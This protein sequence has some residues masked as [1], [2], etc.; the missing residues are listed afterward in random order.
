MGWIR[1]AQSR[2]RK[3]RL[4]E[5]RRSRG[6]VWLHYHNVASS[7]AVKPWETRAETIDIRQNRTETG[8][9]PSPFRSPMK[10]KSDFDITVAEVEL[11]DRHGNTII[12]PVQ[13]GIATN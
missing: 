1:S 7:V 3:A 6:A 10:Q 8:G 11:S 5:G 12:L 2:R 4:L 13:L 9:N